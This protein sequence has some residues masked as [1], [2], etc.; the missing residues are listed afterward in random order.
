MAPP[1]RTKRSAPPQRGSQMRT[2]K[3]LR[4][5]TARMNT[6]SSENPTGDIGLWAAA[7]ERLSRRNKHMPRPRC[8]EEVYHG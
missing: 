3:T 2:V 4:F 5:T 8:H 1:S 6:Y 7:H